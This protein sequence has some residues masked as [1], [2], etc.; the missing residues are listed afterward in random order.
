M[1]L[2]LAMLLLS[3]ETLA[4]DI[5]FVADTITSDANGACSVFSIDI[6]GDGDVDSISASSDDDTIAWLEN[7]NGDGSSWTKHVISTI[8]NSP[9]S[10]WGGDIDGDGDVD[11][12]SASFI[13][14]T[15]NWFEN[16][17]G[18]GSLWTRHIISTEADRANSVVG[19]DVDN[20]G[21]IDGM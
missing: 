5:A 1:M 3:G 11:V 12:M 6:D 2:R 19:V 16:V 21:D 17:N 9:R 20:D 14:D 18:D 10:V 7:E 8:P 15:I 13:D 4:D